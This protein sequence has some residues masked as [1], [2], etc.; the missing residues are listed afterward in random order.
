MNQGCGAPKTRGKKNGKDFES[1][2]RKVG[3]RVEVLML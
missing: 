3:E 1:F 2:G